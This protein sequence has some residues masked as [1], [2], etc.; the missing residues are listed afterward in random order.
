MRVFLNKPPLRVNLN[1]SVTRNGGKI[2][3]TERHKSLRIHT[4]RSA[5]WPYTV[6]LK[7]RIQRANTQFITTLCIADDTS[8]LTAVLGKPERPDLAVIVQLES[9]PFSDRK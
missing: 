9:N 2:N 6:A 4:Q 5:F 1:S 7:S 8:V 3:Y